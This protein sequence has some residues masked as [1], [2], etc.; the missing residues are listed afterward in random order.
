[1]EAGYYRVFLKS[2]DD[3]DWI[4]IYV[5]LD[6]HG[7]YGTGPEPHLVKGL[8]GGDCLYGEFKRS[9]SK[10]DNLIEWQDGM[11]PF[12]TEFLTV[13]VRM[14]GRVHV[15][16]ELTADEREAFEFKVLDVRRL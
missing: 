5:P 8:W 16:Q 4:V 1:M 14:G 9:S 2:T 12:I 11:T 3:E 10:H 7:R 13:P 6:S 15:Y